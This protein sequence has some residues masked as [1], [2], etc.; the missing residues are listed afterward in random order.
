VPRHLPLAAVL[1]GAVLVG[2]SVRD[3]FDPASGFRISIEDPHR[4]LGSPPWTVA[5]FNPYLGPERAFAERAQ[6][7]TSPGAPYIVL[8]RADRDVWSFMDLMPRQGVEFGL[9]L[10]G[11][12]ADGYWL[13]RFE[14]AD[15]R[16]A[17][18]ED[19]RREARRGQ[20][21]FCRW[22]RIAPDAGAESLAIEARD[23]DKEYGLELAVTVRVPAQAASASANR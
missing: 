11:L 3:A 1:L 19:A 21:R 10:P 4:R 8:R 18:S 17:A 9:V 14:G 5:V 12:S 22:G 15:P 2:C 16:L 23:V 20:A 6:G 7:A 13:A